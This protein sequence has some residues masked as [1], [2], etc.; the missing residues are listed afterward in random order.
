MNGEIPC[1]NLISK[2]NWHLDSDALRP[3]AGLRAIYP[4]SIE[5]GQRAP[6]MRVHCSS[7]GEA[8]RLVRPFGGQRGSKCQNF[9][10][11]EPSAPRFH[12]MDLIPLKEVIGQVGKDVCTEMFDAALFI[13][14]KSWKLSNCPTIQDRLH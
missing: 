7:N 1:A 10:F 3:K 12:F 6:V 2:C 14:V 11:A 13:I 5:A 4:P 9:I 8:V